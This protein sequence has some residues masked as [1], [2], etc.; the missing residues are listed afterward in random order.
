M[1]VS[2]SG[3]YS[4]NI[5][6]FIRYLGNSSV[7]CCYSVTSVNTYPGTTS[8]HSDLFIRFITNSTTNNNY[9]ARLPGSDNTT[10][11]GATFKS[12]R[13]DGSVH[14]CW[15]GLTNVWTMPSEST[16]N[17]DGYLQKP[18][19]SSMST[20]LPLIYWHLEITLKTGV[21][22]NIASACLNTKLSPRYQTSGHYLPPIIT[23]NITTS[24]PVSKQP[25]VFTI[26]V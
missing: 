18:T 10:C 9:S 3:D 1:T 22:Y 6:G 7:S 14:L 11:E 8:Q 21:I 13:Y 23:N 16:L 12:L 19:Q 26:L 4:A 5:A 24:P 2:A 25:P 17:L 15:L 20:L